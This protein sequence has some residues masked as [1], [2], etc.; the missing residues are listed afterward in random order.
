M[1]NDQRIYLVCCCHFWAWLLCFI[2][3]SSKIHLVSYRVKYWH[4]TL[5]Y[6]YCDKI[7]V[8]QLLC[9]YLPVLGSK[10]IE[11]SNQ[12]IFLK[13]SR[14]ITYPSRTSNKHACSLILIDLL[15]WYSSFHFL[16]ALSLNI[17]Y[18]STNL[19]LFSGIESL[20]FL[21]RD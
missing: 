8:S 13:K 10:T 15:I 5:R 14:S 21:D 16:M 20:L 19:H 4:L 17:K 7:V 18:S 11:Y 12:K 1:N 2:D 9:Y 3:L 6:W